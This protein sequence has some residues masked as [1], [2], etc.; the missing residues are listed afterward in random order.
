MTRGRSRTTHIKGAAF[1]GRALCLRSKMVSAQ[2]RKRIRPLHNTSQTRPPRNLVLGRRRRCRALPLILVHVGWLAETSLDPRPTTEQLET[3][4]RQCHERADS[5]CVFNTGSGSYVVGLVVDPTG[6]WSIMSVAGE[7]DDEGVEEVKKALSKE[8]A[9]MQAVMG[10]DKQQVT[11]KVVEGAAGTR[12]VVVVGCQRT[13][14]NRRT[15][16]GSSS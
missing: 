2:R 6:A 10:G 8:E 11:L 9:S 14:T 16:K 13:T 5:Q 7:E 3:R 4:M 1:L 12:V 15:R